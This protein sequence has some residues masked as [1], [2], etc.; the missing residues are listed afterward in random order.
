MYRVI[1]YAFVI[2]ASAGHAAAAVPSVAAHDGNIVCTRSDGTRLQLTKL[3]KDAEP[4]LSPDGHTVAFIRTVVPNSESDMRD[5]SFALWTGN[6]QTGA[7]HQLV[8]P[9][10]KTDIFNSVEY[11]VFSLSGANIYV[12]L[13]PGADYL[14]IQRVNIKTRRHRLFANAELAGV[15]RSGPYRGDL[16]ATQHTQLRDEKGMTYGGYP[17]YIF[18]PNGKIIKRL[19]GSENWDDKTKTAWLKKKGWKVW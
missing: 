2:M 17:L 12:S 9:A 10:T 18:N 4:A 16:L 8:Q 11:P 13:V 3:G 19:P 1:A 14:I 15:I 7:A 5:G 6:C